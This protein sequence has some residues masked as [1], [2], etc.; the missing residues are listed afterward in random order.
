MASIL[1]ITCSLLATLSIVT[2]LDHD[3]YHRDNLV[4][5][6]S[7]PEVSMTDGQ[8][9]TYPRANFLDNGSIIGAYTGFTSTDN[10]LTLVQSDDDGGSWYEI[11]TAA[12][13]PSNSSDL[14]NPYPL[15]LPN[16]RVL[17]AYRNHDKVAGSTAD[18]TYFRITL[19]YSDDRGASWRYLSDAVAYPGSQYHGAW[20]PFLRNA[21]DGSLQLYYSHENNASDQDSMMMTSADGGSTWSAPTTISGE[22]IIARDGEKADSFTFDMRRTSTLIIDNRHDRSCH[23]PR[24]GPHCRV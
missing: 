21:L 7:G 4:P 8:A 10:V 15:Q 16:G 24:K 9:G 19:S 14:D 23:R 1:A 12:Q 17:L 5:S 13:R 22:G 18:Y 6:L 20:E 3:V 11:G 2:P